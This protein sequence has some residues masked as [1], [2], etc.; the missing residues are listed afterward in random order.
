M[1][2]IVNLQQMSEATT[3]DRAEQAG[4]MI[5]AVVVIALVADGTIQLFSPSQ[6]A[7]T[8]QETGVRD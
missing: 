1:F 3:S 5:S 2:R 8:L 4:R 7:S 6:I